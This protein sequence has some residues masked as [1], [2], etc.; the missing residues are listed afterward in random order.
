MAHHL[1][2]KMA[3]ADGDEG[4]T[5]GKNVEADAEDEEER[6]HQQLAYYPQQS[7]TLHHQQQDD[8]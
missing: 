4:G 5:P 6:H 2:H 1:P 7:A 3:A 8:A